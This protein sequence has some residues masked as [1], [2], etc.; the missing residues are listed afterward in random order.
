MAIREFPFAPKTSSSLVGV[1]FIEIA[2][3]LEPPPCRLSWC[4]LI[5]TLKKFSS[6][7]SQRGASLTVQINLSV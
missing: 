5:A 1:R 2:N 3:S 7:S 4:E 6:L